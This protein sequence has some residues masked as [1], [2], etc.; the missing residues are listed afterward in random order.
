MT[1]TEARERIKHCRSITVARQLYRDIYRE[2]G[3]SKEL[4]MLAWLVQQEVNDWNEHP[5]QDTWQTLANIHDLPEC[6]K[7]EADAGEIARTGV[8]P[9]YT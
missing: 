1:A 4:Q 3:T 6:V 7:S 2:A 8:D 5:Q 9:R